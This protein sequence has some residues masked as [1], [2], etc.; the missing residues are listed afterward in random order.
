MKISTK[1]WC[2]PPEV[3][4][5]MAKVLFVAMISVSLSG[6][7]ST[8]VAASTTTSNLEQNPTKVELKGKVVDENGDVLPGASVSVKGTTIGM[9]TT[10]EGT[11][12]LNVPNEK[13][14]L[15]VTYVG[16][17]ATE[18]QVL[19]PAKEKDLTITMKED[20]LVAE[21]VV[22]TGFINQRRATFTGTQTTIKKEEIM[23]ISPTNLMNAISVLEPSFRIIENIEMGSDPNTM[24]EAYLRGQSGMS[25]RQLDVSESVSPYETRTNPNLPIFILDGFEISMEKFNDLDPNT[26]ESVT[27]LKDAQ[28]TALYG[29]RASNGVLVITSVPPEPGKLRFHYTLTASVTAPDLRDYH[30]LNAEEKLAQ[31]VATGYYNSS[32]SSAGYLT[33]Y[34]NYML[35]MNNIRRGV[36][37][38]WLAQPLRTQFNQNHSLTITG[39]TN[40]FRFSFGLRYQNEN[41][42]MKESYRDVYNA[43]IGLE[44][45][46][47]DLQIQNK[48][49]LG[50]MERQNSPY[51]SFS[52]YSQL[53]PY[54]SP[55]N[56]NTGELIPK[57][58]GWGGSGR[59]DYTNP[60]Y[61]VH[62]TDNSDE[63]NYTEFTN[64]LLV[65]YMPNPSL[66]IKGQFSVSKKD[67]ATEVFKDPNAAEFDT[68]VYTYGANN[69]L[70]ES[71]KTNAFE[72]GTLNQTRMST[73]SWD[74]KF[75]AT[76]SKGWEKHFVNATAGINASG[77]T[78][79][80]ESRQFKGFPSSSFKDPKY[81]YEIVG[82][83][84]FDDNISRL[85]GYYLVANYSYNDIYMVDFTY[86]RDGS[87]Q[88]GVD[89]KFANFFSAGAGVNFHNMEYFKNN[90]PMLNQLRF[91]ANYGQTGNVS[92]PPYAARTTYEIQTDGWH[93][94]GIGAILVAMGNKNLSWETTHTI[95][96]G[97]DVE[98]NKKWVL[99]FNWYNK[100]TKD[101]ITD[102]SLPPSAGFTSYKDNMGEIENRGYEFKV[103][104]KAI[105]T[106][107]L[108]LNFF[109]N[110][111][112]NKGTIKKISDSMKEYNERV[113]DH[114]ASTSTSTTVYEKPKAKP[115]LKYEEGGSLTAIYA[116]PSL[117]ISPATG[118]EVYMDLWGNPT[119]DWMADHQRIVGNSEPDLSGSFG[120]SF[121]W[122][123]LSVHT[124]FN[125]Q[126]GAD[127]YNTT[128]VER[129]E[130]LNYMGFNCDSRI[131]ELRWHKPGDVAQYKDVNDRT[132]LTRP[133]SRFLQRNDYVKFNSVNVSWDFQGD[134]MDRVGLGILRLSFNMSD[135]HTWS[136]INI[137]RGLSY[138][139]AR[140]FNMTLNAT[141]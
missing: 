51:G 1:A 106:K 64:N 80:H 117:G 137:E 61:D 9:S 75:Q 68:Y 63:G 99:E 66:N 27:I 111:A 10:K 82:N 130:N 136:S 129:V 105:E 125:Y 34:N 100:L 53:L 89:N 81:A 87:S 91:R 132:K 126:V 72:K 85:V 42:V 124:T 69:S 18:I 46:L 138:P 134:W 36:D 8:P 118:D 26:I 123:N 78:S 32:T 79:N 121:R 31:E 29:S 140:T 60:L 116:M 49:G 38:Y 15:V 24:Q 2:Q 83:P 47:P 94:T 97:F 103:N 55:Y 19:N 86:R 141:F 109:V 13:I 50:I 37:T 52:T 112:H 128:L 44:Y 71:R 4:R 57:L 28:A 20:K 107:D 131:M 113:N 110:G 122:K 3:F 133:T 45:R 102:V 101:L 119:Y 30:L 12:A 21:E 73:L 108:G 62:R 25:N 120:V 23:S 135:I 14:T 95:N 48:V 104:Y 56:L 67:E 5:G 139:F 35:K 33:T 90:M 92:Y 43:E 54:D 76:F 115:V 11:F 17:E 98:I 41:G 16:Y 39:G 77:S 74:A 7:F 127:Q 40:E 59:S 6:M 58:T 88:F 65:N 93:S 84:Y 96:L 70:L 22:A 114:F